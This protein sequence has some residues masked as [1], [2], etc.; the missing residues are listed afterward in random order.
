METSDL[1]CATP[2]TI[3]RCSIV[4]VTE[5]VVSIE[6]LSSSWLAASKFSSPKVADFFVQYVVKSVLDFVSKHQEYCAVVVTSRYLF[7]VK[8]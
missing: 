4:C 8:E 5:D 1:N 7:Q 2:S 3:S 6:T